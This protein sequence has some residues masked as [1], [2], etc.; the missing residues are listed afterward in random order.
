MLPH[1]VD[2]P[3]AQHQILKV[4]IKN[5][6][7][8]GWFELASVLIQQ[9]HCSD[10][11]S[12]YQLLRNLLA[13][14]AAL[15]CGTTRPNGPSHAHLAWLSLCE[16][17]KLA[18]I[19]S[20]EPDSSEAKPA[21]KRA[22][23]TLHEAKQCAAEAVAEGE[24]PMTAARSP[25]RFG[26][27]SWATGAAAAAARALSRISPPGFAL[28]ASAEENAPAAGL[29]EEVLA[30]LVLR[31]FVEEAEWRLALLRQMA[32]SIQRLPGRSESVWG[33]GEAL[34]VMQARPEVLLDMCKLRS[35]YDLG[36]QAVRHFALPDSEASALV[37]AEWVESN[38]AAASVESAVSRV[39]CQDE[40][41]GD[42]D[43]EAPPLDFETLRAPLSTLLRLMLCLDVATSS[44]ATS[45]MCQRLLKQAAGLLEELDAAEPDTSDVHAPA[46]RAAAAWWLSMLQ[47]T[48]EAEGQLGLN[49]PL[50]DAIAGVDVL[51][52]TED[53]VKGDDRASVLK[54][55]LLAL[56]KALNLLTEALANAAE[57]KHQFLSGLL[58]NLARS[59]RCEL[60]AKTADEVLQAAGAASG[61]ATALAERSTDGQDALLPG[62]DELPRNYLSNM[63]KYL[64]EVGDELASIDP[65]PSESINY[66][67]LLQEHPQDLLP[68]LVVQMGCTEVAFRVAQ[69]LGTD[70]VT[71]EPLLTH[72]RLNSEVGLAGLEDLADPDHNPEHARQLRRQPSAETGPV[73]PRNKAAKPG[74]MAQ[75]LSD[76]QL[77]SPTGTPGKA[78]QSVDGSTPARRITPARAASRAPLHHPAEEAAGLAA[79]FSWEC[80]MRIRS[81]PQKAD[82]VLR[83][84]HHWELEDA[85]LIT[86]ICRDQSAGHAV[87]DLGGQEPA[88]PAAEL[89]K[90]LGL[91]QAVLASPAG[92]EFRG[93]QQMHSLFHKD[94]EQ[95][96]RR[97]LAHNAGRGAADLA[98]Q[99]DIPDVLRHQAFALHM[100]QLFSQSSSE[101]GGVIGVIRQLQTLPPLSAALSGLRLIQLTPSLSHRQ[102]IAQ[103][104]A[105]FA[106]RLPAGVAARL[107]LARTGIRTLSLLD[108][109]WDAR[110]AHLVER[111]RLMVECLV[112]GQ[113]ATMLQRV[114]KELPA[115][116][117]DAMLLQYARLGVSFAA[118][119]ASDHFI[120]N[121]RGV[122]RK[123]QGLD[124]VLGDEAAGSAGQGAGL[125]AV[126]VLTGDAESDDRLRSSWTF[127]SAPNF[128]IA[129]AFLSHSSSPQAAAQSAILIATELATARLHVDTAALEFSATAMEHM[130]EAASI[131]NEALAFAQ[132]QLALVPKRKTPK[133]VRALVEKLRDSASELG[134]QTGLLQMLLEASVPASLAELCSA[135]AA[136]K[137]VGRLL[138]AEHYA[139]AVFVAKRWELGEARCWEAWAYSLLAIGSYGQAE[140]RLANALRPSSSKASTPEEFAQ[141]AEGVALRAVAALEGTAPINI[142]DLGKLCDELQDALLAEEKAAMSAD[143]YLEVLQV[144]NKLPRASEV[145]FGRP[146]ESE[147]AGKRY[148][149]GER[150]LREHAP[151]HLLRFMFKHG[152]AAAACQLLYP[153]VPAA[154]GKGGMPTGHTRLGTL[155]ALCQLAV[156]F[157]EMRT[158][159]RA[160]SAAGPAGHAALRNVCTWLEQ[161]GHLR[162]LYRCQ[163][164]LRMP[165]AA[166]LTC[167]HLSWAADDLPSAVIHLENA[168]LHLN[169]ALAFLQRSGSGSAPQARDPVVA[170][171]GG[172]LAQA[173]TRVQLQADVYKSV[174]RAREAEERKRGRAAKQEAQAAPKPVQFNLFA[175]GEGP[176][177]AAETEE[178][179]Q[180]ILEFLIEKDFNLAFRI[181]HAFGINPIRAYS[182]TAASLASR[183]EH[184]SLFQLLQSIRNTLAASELDSVLAAAVGGYA[185]G[186]PAGGNTASSKFKGKAWAQ[187]YLAGGGFSAAAPAE[188][189]IKMMQ[190]SHSRVQAYLRLGLLPKALEAAT[191]SGS[192][193]SLQLVAEEARRRQDIDTLAAADARLAQL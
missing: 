73:S 9:L 167:L 163:L 109:P 179:R 27:S 99:A 152:Q 131:V 38:M 190:S 106:D 159:Q 29:A 30:R 147:V 12:A 86:E 103:T 128:K 161:H 137:L 14:G 15:E 59:T 176:D 184:T 132:D 123:V 48:C 155:E 91:Y 116:H 164:A 191:A 43:E 177:T 71:E 83:L 125:V 136:G 119:H 169:D 96:V 160:L 175:D 193:V 110:C 115:L 92:A 98:A 142:P 162:H 104:I 72:L 187:N 20:G 101:G 117:D 61:L 74:Q 33:F 150:L 100:Q 64:A 151:G 127:R 79:K 143:S 135:G 80:C 7:S 126:E 22:Q 13:Q 181:V 60:N 21:N 111:P 139:L 118:M 105:G 32:P 65:A 183:R 75:N 28:D 53:T 56:D 45:T 62:A 121:A 52:V 46:L 114:L 188:R 174:Q 11:Q 24:E 10:Q 107:E 108:S 77:L 148:E 36:D 19:P 63:L 165:D 39:A 182:S 149:M 133:E 78:W 85:L 146:A 3:D 57:G 97:L 185:S 90:L 112:M 49:R 34:T 17:R 130:L 16:L 141:E 134:K 89:G 76:T 40:A 113:Q 95:L 192:R 81:L 157:E 144:S 170:L 145:A 124:G 1:G 5:Y 138:A 67:S 166:G 102:V 6:V 51:P 120:G 68:R 26:L 171:S 122:D 140:N 35:R 2:P 173:V 158:L 18:S 66:F 70:L 154:G 88:A 172:S 82:L 25:G 54:R 129:R 37:L 84:V 44:A 47:E 178:R 31:A 69:L 189:V 87:L 4:L 93:W 23:T 50:R 55:Q 42:V 153:P 8:R 168:L 58:H 180:R 186:M 41:P 156:E 94:P